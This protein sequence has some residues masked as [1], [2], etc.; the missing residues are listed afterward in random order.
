MDLN[1]NTTK[2]FKNEII[3]KNSNPYKSGKL[4]INT[5]FAFPK[6]D[7]EILKDKSFQANESFSLSVVYQNFETEGTGKGI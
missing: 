5:N 1:E 7:I 4:I 2:Y 3:D 6:K